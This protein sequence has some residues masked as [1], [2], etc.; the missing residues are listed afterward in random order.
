M[1]A[2]SVSQNLE[3]VAGPEKKGRVLLHRGGPMAPLDRLAVTTGRLGPGSAMAARAA[4]PGSLEG[5]YDTACVPLNPLISAE[6]DPIRAA[7]G[8]RAEQGRP[9]AAVLGGGDEASSHKS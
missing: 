3:L 2:D 6:M 5:C 8:G 9:V 4:Q 7:G 1:R